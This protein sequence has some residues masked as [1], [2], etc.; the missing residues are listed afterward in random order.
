MHQNKYSHTM[1]ML[2]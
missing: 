1:I 2:T